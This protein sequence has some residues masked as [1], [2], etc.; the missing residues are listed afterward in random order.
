MEELKETIFGEVSKLGETMWSLYEDVVTMHKEVVLLHDMQ[1]KCKDI[2]KALK[3][4]HTTITVV[5][6]HSMQYKG[7]P[8]ELAKK[9]RP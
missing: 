5:C 7:A 2:V 1:Q 8:A 4:V 6:E 3:S 9:I